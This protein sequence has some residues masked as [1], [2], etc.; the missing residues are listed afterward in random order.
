MAIPSAFWTADYEDFV[1]PQFTSQTLV[2]GD[3]TSRSVNDDINNMGGI[4]NVRFDAISLDGWVT[5]LGGAVDHGDWVGSREL[6]RISIENSSGTKLKFNGVNCGNMASN[7][8]NTRL[9][10]G[11]GKQRLLLPASSY[12][13]LAKAWDFQWATMLTVLT[14]VDE[15]ATIKMEAPTFVQGTPAEAAAALMLHANDRHSLA[16]TFDADT[17]SDADTGQKDPT[18]GLIDYFR[19]RY[20]RRPG[21]TYADALLMM[22]RHSHDLLAINMSGELA[23]Y[24]RHGLD[25]AYIVTS[26]DSDDGVVSVKWRSA[27]EHLA[28]KAF[29]SWGSWHQGD[30]FR[31]YDAGGTGD[32]Q[33][34]YDSLAAADAPS[35]DY[36]DHYE[37]YTNAASV[38]K[39]GERELGGGRV[40]F[41]REV[42]VAFGTQTV[43][44][45]AERQ[46][47]HLPLIQSNTLTAASG[48]ILRDN[49]MARLDYDSQLRRE[50]TVVQ[51]FRG[52]DYDVGWAVQDVAVTKDAET[53]GDTRCIRK[54]IDFSDFTVTS[55][56]LE[57]PPQVI[58]TFED[59]APA[60]DDGD[61]SYFVRSTSA[62]KNGAYGIAANGGNVYRTAWD[63][64]RSVAVNGC[65]IGVW[66]KAPDDGSHEFKA[67]GIHFAG[68]GVGDG[69]FQAVID[70]RGPA[71]SLRRD[72]SSSNDINSSSNSAVQLDVW[73]WLEV[74]GS[75]TG[76]TATLYDEPGGTA[77]LS[78]TR[79]DTT[80]T[81]GYVGLAVYSTG[82]F[83]DLT[84]Y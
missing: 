7:D 24:R 46:Y 51:D 53:I 39:Y 13:T 1:Y 22:A 57:E 48:E 31:V 47:F 2:D 69:G 81:T 5:F 26:L 36:Y 84:I 74:I 68:T 54:V 58:Y 61:K 62:A 19:V 18:T 16:I 12:I 6:G 9:Y 42:D 49:Y 8:I 27:W 35:S 52:L 10:Q 73:Y 41:D 43:E 40:L 30:G 28:N 70:M 38:T 15:V 25:S 37:E 4:D 44:Y 60:I 78:A 23:L 66:I 82:H 56:L 77:L 76:F 65:K 67:P 59:T 64:D 29:V 55:V 14:S 17:W 83:D 45:I 3:R 71:L 32:E 79:N 33:T 11:D 34:F 21:K 50:I 63:T 80:Y 20:I 72:F 75:S